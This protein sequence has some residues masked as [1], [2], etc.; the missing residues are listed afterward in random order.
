[1]S[2]GVVVGP[3][4]VPARVSLRR[5][6]QGEWFVEWGKRRAKPLGT[7]DGILDAFTALETPRAVKEF[8]QRFGP[9]GLCREHRRNRLDIEHGDCTPLHPEPV[10][11]WLEYSGVVSSIRRV[12]I[13]LDSGQPPDPYGIEVPK[14]GAADRRDNRRNKEYLTIEKQFRE[15]DGRGSERAAEL[16]TLADEHRDNMTVKDDRIEFLRGELRESLPKNTLEWEHWI[17]AE[18]NQG[19]SEHPPQLRLSVD[20]ARGRVV[21]TLSDQMSLLSRVY[22]ELALSVCGVG[23]VAFCSFCGHPYTPLRAP[24]R[25]Q[26]NFC[27]PCRSAGVH[28]RLHARRKRVGTDRRPKS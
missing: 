5:D 11:L 2:F 27:E 9:L 1:M 24:K 3:A 20:E 23:G 4:S 12:R 18:V 26:D 8:V 7:D 21:P 14:D 15:L 22:L 25:G 16:R 10:A 19:L 17:A 28:K 13:S 6:A